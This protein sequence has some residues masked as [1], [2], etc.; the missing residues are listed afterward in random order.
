MRPL[1]AVECG[2]RLQMS[3]IAACS[4]FRTLFLLC[5]GVNG[6][7]EF[8][9]CFS[10]CRLTVSGWESNYIS[11][12]FLHHSIP[13]SRNTVTVTL[14]EVTNSLPNY[15]FIL[16]ITADRARIMVCPVVYT[17]FFFY[18]KIPI[19]Y[20]ISLIIKKLSL[21]DLEKVLRS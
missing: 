3:T 14:T 18:H 19:L 20:L 4:L 10:C 7:N 15:W 17:L 13:C 9:C 6:N 1:L 11:D 21:S 12:L 16:I 2:H 5:E 8:C